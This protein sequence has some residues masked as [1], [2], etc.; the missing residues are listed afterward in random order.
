M[1]LGEKLRQA[2]LEAGL[3]QRQLCEQI[4]TRNMLS[5]I[6]NGSAR[7]SMETLKELAARLRQPVSYFLEEQALVS[8]NTAVMEA[9]RTAFDTGDFSGTL[10]KL[11]LCRQPDPVY[12]RE[13]ELLQTLSLLA[14]AERAI[15]ESRFPY[16]LDLLTRAQG[17]TAYLGEDLARRRLLL[18]GRIPGQGVS[19]ELPSL[20]EELLIRASEALAAGRQDRAERLLEAAEDRENPR[21]NLLRGQ[22][23]MENGTFRKAV[24]YLQKAEIPLSGQAVPLL[25]QC[26]RELKDYKKAY[27]YAC[28]GR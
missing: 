24:R 18:L 14:L 4:I 28:K 11:A 13:A 17:K 1:E 15:E 19:E 10:E 3:S 25:E 7:P 26:Y 27:E 20:D 12:C 16:A 21:W 23:C 5:L 9:A 8:P 6:E 2:R 22:V